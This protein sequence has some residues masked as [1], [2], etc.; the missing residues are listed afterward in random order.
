MYVRVTTIQLQPGKV[1]EAIRIYQDSVVSAAKQQA[2]FRSTTLLIDRA[3]NKGIAL[4]YWAAEADLL[5]SEASGYYNEQVA[6]FAPLFAAP[7]VREIYE[8]ATS[9]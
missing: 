1:D 8:V 5:A 9:A 2:G 3:A 6:K 4:T 7:P